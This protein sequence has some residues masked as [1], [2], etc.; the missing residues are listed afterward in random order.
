MH[1]AE[2]IAVERRRRWSW[3]DK[4]QIV[5][6]TLMP[7]ASI[8]ALARLRGHLSARNSSSSPVLAKDRSP[9]IAADSRTIKDGP[10]S[11]HCRPFAPDFCCCRRL[12]AARS[13]CCPPGRW[14]QRSRRGSACSRAQ[15]HSGCSGTCG[16]VWSLS[17][18]S[19]HE[20]GRIVSAVSG[21]PF[22]HSLSLGASSMKAG[23]RG[24][25]R[26]AAGD[27][28][29]KHGSPSRDYGTFCWPAFGGQIMSRL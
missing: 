22:T 18:R 10:P 24:R 11:T 13:W 23:D 27:V 16:S 14:R 17:R 3:S 20:R 2:V 5:E 12:A 25:R 6:E 21:R 7:G 4:Q 28:P 29:P 9:P 8:S 1:R 15:A 19:A 26:V